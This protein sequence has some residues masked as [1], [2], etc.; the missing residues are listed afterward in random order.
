MKIK[1]IDNDRRINL[2]IGKTYEIISINTY[3]NYLIIDD[4]D[5][6]DWYRKKLFKSLSE[7][8]AEKIDKLLA[9]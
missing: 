6:E 2:T 9:E 5:H 8:R 3:D 1:C 7:I 4:A